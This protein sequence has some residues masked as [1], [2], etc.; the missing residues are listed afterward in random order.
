MHEY[1]YDCNAKFLN[2]HV[3]DS[4]FKNSNIESVEVAKLVEVAKA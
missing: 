4:N 3:L 2:F 1:D